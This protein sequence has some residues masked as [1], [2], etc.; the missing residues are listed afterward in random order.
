MKDAMNDTMNDRDIRRLARL[1]SIN[2]RDDE[3]EGVRS[4]I[5]EIMALI[6]DLLDADAGS[7]EPLIHPIANQGQY[8][9]PDNISEENERERLQKAA[10]AVKK[11]L[12]QV[13][14]VLDGETRRK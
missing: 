12:Y 14:A 6:D 7:L 5:N 2:I 1:A 9:R 3:I 13:P 10:P 11:G 8:L 4:A